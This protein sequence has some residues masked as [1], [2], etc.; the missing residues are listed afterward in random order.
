MPA[1][2]DRQT[3]HGRPLVMTQTLL[4]IAVET[5][6]VRAVWKIGTASDV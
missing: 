1:I 5:V 4:A 6:T 2:S 3:V